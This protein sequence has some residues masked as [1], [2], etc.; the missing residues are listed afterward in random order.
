MLLDLDSW[1]TAWRQSLAM[2]NQHRNPLRRR[3]EVPLVFAGAPWLQE[4]MREAAPDLWSVR[5]G[6]VRI[7]PGRVARGEGARAGVTLE[8]GGEAAEDPDY[9]LEVAERLR[10]TKEQEP[11]RVD[12]LLRAAWGFDE[13]ARLEAAEDAF[14]EAVALCRKLAKH[15]PE[16]FLPRLAESLTG[17]TGAFW[18]S[19]KLEEGLLTGQEALAIYRELAAKPPQVYRSK[20]ELVE[21]N[22]K[23]LDS[24]QSAQP[25]A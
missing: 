21:G 14:R 23:R 4:V 20:V 17:L 15:S 9:A 3:F 1:K 16:E 11:A 8:P 7:I 2:L 12:L 25:Q 10:N 22:L 24:Q 5:T 19:E 18:S 6:V 13:A